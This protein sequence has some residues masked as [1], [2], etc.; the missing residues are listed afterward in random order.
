MLRKIT[1]N[2]SKVSQRLRV[3]IVASKYN[4]ELTDELLA[5]C[6]RSLNQQGVLDVETVRVPGCYE[7]PVMVS[8][9]ARSKKPDAIIA[10]GVVIQGK[11]SHAEHITMASSINLQK[12]AI[13]TGI[14]VIHQILSPKNMHDGRDRVRLR[15]IEAAQ[16]AV[17]MA[18]LTKKVK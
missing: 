2:S 10:L 4:P 9:L 12:I 17:E 14:P 15:G 16:T 11:T 18:V 6:L 7:I 1:K 3:A 8:R 13:D 5:H